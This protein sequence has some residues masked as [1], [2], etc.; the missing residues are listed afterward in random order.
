[1]NGRKEMLFLFTKKVTD[2]NKKNCR[3]VLLL[4]ICG[5]TFERLIYNNFFDFTINNN[6]ISSNQS[7]RG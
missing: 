2:K 3:L 5:N 6:L 7:V 1:M 4:P